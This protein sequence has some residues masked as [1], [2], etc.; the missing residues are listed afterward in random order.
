[1]RANGF[2]GGGYARTVLSGLDQ[3]AQSLDTLDELRRTSV[4]F[5]ALL[6]SISRQ[7]RAAELGI[8]SPETPP[9]EN[10]YDDPGA[11]PKP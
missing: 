4:D 7:H 9:A 5:Y 3:F 6:R 11:Q 10:I 2:S 1:M 8:T